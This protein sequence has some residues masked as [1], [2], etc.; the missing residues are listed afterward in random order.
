[1]RRNDVSV[2]VHVGAL[3]FTN[4]EFTYWYILWLAPSHTWLLLIPPTSA[5]M[6]VTFFKKIYFIFTES[7]RTRETFNLL[8]YSPNTCNG[9]S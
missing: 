1:M 8:V 9:W 7:E 3:L 2:A 5:Y 4:D 6:H